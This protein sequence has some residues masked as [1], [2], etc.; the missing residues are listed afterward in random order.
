MGGA[1]DVAKMKVPRRQRESCVSFRAEA[2][3]RSRRIARFPTEGHSTGTT[4][5]PH[6]PAY[7]GHPRGLTAA[8][9][10]I[11]TPLANRKDGVV[12]YGV[13]Q[14][15]REIGVRVALGATSRDVLRLIVGRSIGFV[16]TGALIGLLAALGLTR[17]MRGL[18]YGMTATD[19]LTLVLAVVALLGVATVVSYLPA[20]RV[21]R[22]DPVRALYDWTD[23]GEKNELESSSLLHRPGAVFLR[24]RS[25]DSALEGWG[26]K[27]G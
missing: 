6:R 4:A 8:P 13:Q 25:C 24:V 16:A 9:L 15:V 14:R 12:A 10:G 22:M 7:G 19:P 1:W 21:A 18:L 17:F 11:T 20:R 2:Q 3:R 5:I 26:W 23:R 27:R